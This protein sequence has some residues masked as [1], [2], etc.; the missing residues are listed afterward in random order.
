MFNDLPEEVARKWCQL[1]EAEVPPTLHDPSNSSLTSSFLLPLFPLAPLSVPRT[2]H[3]LT[4]LSP[5]SL[6]LSP[7]L[8]R[9]I[10]GIAKTLIFDH[11]D[12]PPPQY[13]CHGSGASCVL[14]L[15]WLLEISHAWKPQRWK[16]MLLYSKYSFLSLLSICK[17]R[18]ICTVH[19]LR[20]AT[21]EN[22]D[23]WPLL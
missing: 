8:N 23:Q 10:S 12:P 22:R 3:L 20:T 13:L 17:H 16:D 4:P 18:C 9:G 14:P 5:Q 11:F 1:R 19:S 15:S 7:L 6:S 2:L 21:H